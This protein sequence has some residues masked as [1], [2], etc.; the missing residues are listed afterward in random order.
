[1]LFGFT[2]PWFL[3][4]SGVYVISI[5]YYFN[6]IPC[7]GKNKAEQ[8]L[9]GNGFWLLRYVATVRHEEIKSVHL[10]L[11]ALPIQC[12]M[13]QRKGKCEI[14]KLEKVPLKVAWPVTKGLSVLTSKPH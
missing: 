6:L 9:P 8:K 3:R 12:A 2:F 11:L 14:M 10:L 1:M 4:W 5:N 13:P 7:L